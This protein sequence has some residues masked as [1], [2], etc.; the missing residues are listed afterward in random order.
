MKARSQCPT[1]QA[2]I[3]DSIVDDSALAA[4]AD[5]APL[6][7][8]EEVAEP[9]QKVVVTAEGLRSEIMQAFEKR[10]FEIMEELRKSKERNLEAL[11]DQIRR[12][13][14]L[15]DSMKP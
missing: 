10:R 14:E 15:M 12:N 13:R 6:L 4:A 2:A 3:T 11:I 8:G 9:G 5:Q 7:G 1:P